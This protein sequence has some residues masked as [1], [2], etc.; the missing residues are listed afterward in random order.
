MSVLFR[1]LVFGALTLPYGCPSSV[2]SKKNTFLIIESLH[3]NNFII[4]PLLLALLS[5]I[6]SS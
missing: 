2:N 3:Q 5:L 4:T 1:P 6:K